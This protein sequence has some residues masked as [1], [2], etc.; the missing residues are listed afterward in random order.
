M[1]AVG[2]IFDNGCALHAING[3]DGRLSWRI[4]WATVIREEAYRAVWC[5]MRGDGET[6]I[7]IDVGQL[8]TFAFPVLN[9]FLDDAENQSRR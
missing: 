9:G 5:I 1:E 6:S 4:L 3:F 8:L 2:R 7:R